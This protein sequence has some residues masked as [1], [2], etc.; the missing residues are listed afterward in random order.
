MITELEQLQ[1][2]IF[3]KL[4]LIISHLQPDSECEEYFGYSFQLNQFSIKFRKAKITPKKIGQFVTLWKRNPESKQTEPFTSEDPFDFYIIFCN[5]NDQSGFFFFS[6][7]ILIQKN[8]LTTLSKDGKRGFRVY[9]TWDSP[10]N[11]QATKTQDWQ[12]HFFID[13]SNENLIDD[14][15]SILRN[16][17]K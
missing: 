15:N 4:N 7:E 1:N 11:K 2:S 12:K 3:S 5:N 16:K 10:E 13:F 6:K 9:P 8:I 17:L 14:F